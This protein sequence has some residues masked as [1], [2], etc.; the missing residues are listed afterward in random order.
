[1]D[2]HLWN[3]SCC[4]RDVKLEEQ[5]PR[6]QKRS[7]TC[8]RCPLWNTSRFQMFW[9]WGPKPMW[10]NSK[11][12]HIS[13][14]RL[15]LLSRLQ[16]SLTYTEWKVVDWSELMDLM[17]RSLMCIWAA[18]FEIPAVTCLPV[19]DLDR[20]D[21]RWSLMP[22]GIKPLRV[23][24]PSRSAGCFHNSRTECL[25]HGGERCRQLVHLQQKGL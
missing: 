8:R 10:T 18:I 4:L 25:C 1:M 19:E 2:R 3:S 21:V 5:Y 13:V 12:Q 22:V 14:S 6:M 16:P 11:Q 23:N 9:W 24:T 17:S 7:R 20:S 15:L